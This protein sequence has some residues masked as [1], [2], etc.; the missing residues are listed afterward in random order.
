MRLVPPSRSLS[1]T[2]VSAGMW[3]HGLILVAL[4]M[5]VVEPAHCAAL[6]QLRPVL[7][8]GGRLLVNCAQYFTQRQIV[9]CAHRVLQPIGAERLTSPPEAVIPLA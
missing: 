7:C 4:C 5:L 1:G 8:R 9:V 3:L 6:T 2:S